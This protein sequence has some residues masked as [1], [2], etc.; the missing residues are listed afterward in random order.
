MTAAAAVSICRA[1]EHR[2]ARV[3]N[4]LIELLPRTARSSLLA[5]CEPVDLVLSEVLCAPGEPAGHVYFPIDGFVSLVTLIGAAQGIEV[6]MVGREGMVGAQF[7]LGVSN[8]PF[9]ALVQG[10][11]AA[12][13]VTARALKRELRSNVALQ[14]CL[15]RYIYVLMVQLA[16]S[17]V[18]L[19]YHMVAPRLARWL[20]MSQDRAHADSFRMTH[21]F[22]AYMLGVRRVG[23]TMAAGALQRD[24][25][26]E[27]SRGEL[28][29]LDRR[30]LEGVACT[31]YR[32]NLRTYAELLK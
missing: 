32:S 25:L 4:H 30:G 2:V 14:A 19:R 26:I 18:C 6:G 22:L 16:S 20:L 3:E 1:S 28:H 17:A 9:H 21:E 15:H 29:V 8:T 7:A 5:I 11:G 12:W 13:R 23:V 24:G 27:Y 10:G 31:C